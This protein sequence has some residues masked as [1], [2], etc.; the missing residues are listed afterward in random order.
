M[1]KW[2]RRARSSDGSGESYTT[3]TDN[4]ADRFLLGGSDTGRHAIATA[5]QYVYETGDWMNVGYEPI[6][7]VFPP[8]KRL[9]KGGYSS[10]PECSK[11]KKGK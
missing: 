8:E 3:K 5:I 11:K 7:V 9:F 2:S 10:H 6:G 1:I 4:N